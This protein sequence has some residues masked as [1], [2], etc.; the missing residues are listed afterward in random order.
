MAR[1]WLERQVEGYVLA[2]AHRVPVGVRV[3]HRPSRQPA[4][5]LRERGRIS[6]FQGDAA[7]PS[8]SGHVVHATCRQATAHRPI[9]TGP[10]CLSL[11]SD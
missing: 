3:D 2:L 4:V 9:Q 5:E 10:A 11:L 8:N 6:A 1:R 7:Q